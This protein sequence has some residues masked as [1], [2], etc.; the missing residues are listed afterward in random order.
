MNE[1]E[2]GEA[3]GGPHETRH[4]LGK[5]ELP[6][7]GGF[8]AR[9]YEVIFEAE[10]PAGKAF[11]V[12][13]LVTIVVSVIAV[14]L[15]SVTAFRQAHGTLLRAAE[16]T[17]TVLFLAEY[18]MRM[19]SVRSPWRYALSFFGI[20]DLGAILPT[21]ISLLY[22]GAQSLLVIRAFRL[23]RV[24]RVFK[25]MR[26]VGEANVLVNAMRASLPKITVFTGAVLTVALLVGASM[27]FIEGE[28]SGFTSIP[29]GM[30]W[31]IV[32]MTTVGF[33]DIT[34]VTIGGRFLASAVMMLG[35]GVI[36]VPMGL[37]SAEIVHATRALP[38]RQ[39]PHC[40]HAGHDADAQFCKLCG[41]GLGRTP[42][43]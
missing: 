11:D 9:L 23:L 36:A 41:R 14:V 12:A 4:A 1:G 27:Y 32:T 2:T 3:R 15:E 33:G 22:P 35:Y 40:L 38:T 13:L 5:S 25:L 19:L 31:A 20:V 34:P 17:F 30:Y 21:F 29:V 42:V 7:L 10:T 6:P 18:A 26:F 28:E 24:F 37:V 16:W 39:C 8:R 43:P